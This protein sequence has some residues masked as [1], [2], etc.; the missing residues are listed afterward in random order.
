[1]SAKLGLASVCTETIDILQCLTNSA[2]EA[3]R[4][5]TESNEED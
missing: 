3:H 4:G 2:F 5:N 1:M